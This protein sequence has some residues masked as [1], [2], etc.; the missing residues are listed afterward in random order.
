MVDTLLENLSKDQALAMK[1]QFSDNPT[2][3]GILDAR[4]AEIESE[5]KAEAVK[6]EFLASLPKPA[7]PPD[8]VHNIF[9]RWSM[10]YRHLTKA[11]KVEVKKT[12]PDITQEDLDKKM[13][14]VGWGWNEWEFN[15]GFTVSSGSGKTTSA[16]KRAIT[17]KKINEDDTLTTIGNFPSAS[18]ACEHLKINIGGDSASR[19]LDREGY[20]R[21]PY[22]G[23]EY[24]AS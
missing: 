13:V 16:S 14:E 4:I 21:V 24:T 8:G 17:V 12:I 1:E 15:K 22:T 19:V 6:V 2:I 11:E 5:E 3:V 18:V 10:Q 20:V 23:T 9:A 7:N